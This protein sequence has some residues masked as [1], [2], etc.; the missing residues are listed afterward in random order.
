MRLYEKLEKAESWGKRLKII[1]EFF[2]SGRGPF[3][4]ETNLLSTRDHLGFLYAIGDKCSLDEPYESKN[5][6]LYI[7]AIQKNKKLL[8]VDSEE[9]I[10]CLPTIQILPS[11]SNAA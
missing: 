9:K 8:I 7:L 2:S 10:Y 11:I 6:P 3:K 5:Y 4:K 1:N